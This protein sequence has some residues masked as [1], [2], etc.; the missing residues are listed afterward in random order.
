MLHLSEDKISKMCAYWNSRP[1][2]YFEHIGIELNPI[3]KFQIIFF[4]TFYKLSPEY[5]M[6][7]I[8]IKKV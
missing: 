6:R 4:D 3:Q 2:E 7:N 1:F 8:L 5:K